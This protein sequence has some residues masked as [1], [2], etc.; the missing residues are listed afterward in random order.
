MHPEQFGKTSFS[1]ICCLCGIVLC[2]LSIVGYV[3]KDH[4]EIDHVEKIISMFVRYLHVKRKDIKINCWKPY[5]FLNCMND[6]FR[7]K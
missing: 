4:N 5:T 6:I 3:I 7:F 2:T 1:D